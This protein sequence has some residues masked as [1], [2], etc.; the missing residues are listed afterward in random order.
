MIV[1]DT[2]RTA[3]TTLGNRPALHVE[4]ESTPRAGTILYFH[5]GG[6]VFGSPETALSLTGHLVARTGF[7]AY[8]LDYRPAPSIRSRPR[9]KTP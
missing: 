9:S 6:W 4:P 5:G 7:G 8:S 3:R 2:I 1:P